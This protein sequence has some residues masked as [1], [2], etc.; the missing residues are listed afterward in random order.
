ML[1][2]VLILRCDLRIDDHLATCTYPNTRGAVYYGDTPFCPYPPSVSIN[3]PL[4]I[5]PN[6]SEPLDLISYFVDEHLMK[7]AENEDTVQFFR[8]YMAGFVISKRES[9]VS[10]CGV[11]PMVNI[12]VDDFDVTLRDLMCLM[13]STT[14]VLRNESLFSDS[15]ERQNVY[16]R[17]FNIPIT[18]ENATSRSVFELENSYREKSTVQ[19]PNCNDTFLNSTMLML[20]TSTIN[21]MMIDNDFEVD[22]VIRQVSDIIPVSGDQLVGRVYVPYSGTGAIVYYNNQVMIPLYV[23]SIN[24]YCLAFPY[25]C[26]CTECFPY[27]LSASFIRGSQC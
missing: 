10:R 1:L 16:P 8:E 15:I 9:A 14:P 3:H 19:Y 18:Y 12:D 26:R 4:P 7:T 22:G 2:Y 24:F 25:A 5:N 11:D 21:A 17:D 6:D 27:C 20:D 23:H 13:I